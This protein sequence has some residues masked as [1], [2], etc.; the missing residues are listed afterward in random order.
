MQIS[1]IFTLRNCLDK[2]VGLSYIHVL[3][4]KHPKQH[5]MADRTFFGLYKMVR[6]VICQEAG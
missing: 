5:H 2:K 3:R 4:P 6:N 1:S